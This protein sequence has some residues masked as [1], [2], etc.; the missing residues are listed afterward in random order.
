MMEF[1]TAHLEL[2]V[3]MIAGALVLAGLFL[4]YLQYQTR[5]KLS[6]ELTELSKVKKH[7]VEYELVLK[8]MKLCTWRI[9][10]PTRTITYESDFRDKVDNYTPAPGT[11]I[12]E[13]EKMYT[14]EYRH[15]VMSAMNDLIEGKVEEYHEQ[16]KVKIPRSD[17][18]YWS[19]GFATVSERDAQGKPLVIVGTTMRIDD[20]KRMENAIITARNQAEEANRLKS[21]FLANIS[22]EIR[23]PL[24]AIVGFSE[25]LPMVQDEAE[26]AELLALIKENN[27][28]LLSLI[29]DMVS[30]S[31]VESGTANIH[32]TVFDLNIILHEIANSYQSQ[33]HSD[34]VVV[35]TNLPQKTCTIMTDRQKLIEIIN[36][37]MT[38]AL[39]FT[40]RGS[41]TLG[42]DSVKDGKIRVWVQDTGKGIPE[43]E[44]GRIFERFVKLD[45]FI[46]GTGLGL[47]LCRSI[48]YSL[49]GNVGVESKVDEGSLFWVELPAEEDE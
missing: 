17:H 14:D 22:H 24:N 29:D 48:A 3:W 12:R 13:V 20:R 25:V 9:D 35:Q 16:F 34:A 8:A 40:R 6:A 10:V 4:L 2:I 47:S 21:A 37:Y 15:R 38:N 44:L 1:V 45:E 39:K 42:Y 5:K 36:H 18:S 41:V 27:A 33:P 7:N 19:E 46:Q 26:R 30:M 11:P 32:K 28:K 49:N 31:K 23:T 43:S